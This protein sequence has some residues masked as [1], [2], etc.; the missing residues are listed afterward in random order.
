MNN[1][2][3]NKHKP[4]YVVLACVLLIL[5]LGSSLYALGLLNLEFKSSESESEPGQRYR[6]IS[7]SE[8]QTACEEHAREAFGQRL[9]LL[10]MDKFS[11]RLDREEDRY[12]FFFQAEL[13]ADPERQGLPQLYYVNCFTGIHSPKVRNFEYSADGQDF[14]K[15]GEEQKSLFGL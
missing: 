14:V 4:L 3:S 2:A 11:S 7:M 9:F 5:M 1:S 8:V 13:F 6:H 12:K 15:P 10:T